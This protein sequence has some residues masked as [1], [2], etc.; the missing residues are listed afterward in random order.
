MCVCVCLMREMNFKCV[1]REE[2]N[3]RITFDS[4]QEIK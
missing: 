3:T 1:Q 4:E 2:N